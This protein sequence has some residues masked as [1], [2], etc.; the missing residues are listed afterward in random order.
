M[1]A[2]TWPKREIF[3]LNMLSVCVCVVREQFVR[4]VL[5]LDLGLGSKSLS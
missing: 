2:S 5:G 3:S 4:F 1:T